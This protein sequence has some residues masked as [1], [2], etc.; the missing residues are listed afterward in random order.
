MFARKIKGPGGQ[1]SKGTTFVINCS[2]IQYKL[3]NIQY[4]ACL[5]M[6]PVFFFLPYTSNIQYV[7]QHSW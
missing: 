3:S 6:V 4:H 5:M 1:V 2:H 7:A